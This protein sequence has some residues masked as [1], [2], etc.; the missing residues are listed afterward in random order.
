MA[1]CSAKTAKQSNGTPSFPSCGALPFESAQGSRSNGHGG[2]DHATVIS[3]L[4]ENGEIVFQQRRAQASS[5]E[6]LAE[7]RRLVPARN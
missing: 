5:D 3:V 4:D 6:L 2:F 7:L 1:D